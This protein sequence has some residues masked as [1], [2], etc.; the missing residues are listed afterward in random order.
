MNAI[1]RLQEAVKAI[2]TRFLTRSKPEAAHPLL[3]QEGLPSSG[4][5]SRS[6]RDVP[7]ALTSTAAERVGALLRT[8]LQSVQAHRL[9]L[10]ERSELLATTLRESER[11]GMEAAAELVLPNEGN[12]VKSARMESVA[13]ADSAILRWV[14]EETARMNRNNVTRT[15]AYQR[16]YSRHPELHWA[17]LAHMVSRNSG[18]NMTDLKGDL[19]PK[20]IGNRQSEALYLMLER[21]NALIFQDAYPQLLL[22][23]EGKRRGR[24]LTFLLERLPVSTFMP[25]LWDDFAE[26][27][28][29]VPLA[30]GL[31]INE[32]NYIQGRVV[33]NPLFVKSVLEQPFFHAESL[34]HV[35]QV[36]FPY[37]TNAEN[38]VRL[39]GITLEDFPD[40]N[41]RIR[42]GRKL[43]ALLFGIATVHAGCRSF[44]DKV[45]HTGSRADYWPK[46][47]SPT[48]QKPPSRGE[49]EVSGA[50]SLWYSPTL[51]AAW[52]N[53]PVEPAVP[54]DW[55]RDMSPLKHFSALKPPA[56]WI[57]DR[58]HLNL[59][60]AQE[61]ALLAKTWSKPLA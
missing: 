3:A 1:N 24:R 52:P 49:M 21:A 38:K 8:A 51:A 61:A 23:Q 45:P 7:P 43:Y 2:K 46:L 33:E 5:K 42:F 6:T 25:P 47:F 17:F 50:D 31:I 16:I 9:D 58:E 36:L 20:L 54:A 14:Q 28:D 4:D 60:K 53:R 13:D 32:Q 19:V 26:T 27:G 10:R 29:P 48:K 15:Y 37:L 35:N 40:L 59:L 44:A 57:M 34:L 39:A 41:E 56:S 22:Y 18:W 55:F 30:I 11:F 12:P